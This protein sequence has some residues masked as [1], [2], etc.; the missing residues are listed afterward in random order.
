MFNGISADL[1]SFLEGD[2]PVVVNVYL[3]YFQLKS[4]I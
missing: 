4:S 1:S 2:I 3:K